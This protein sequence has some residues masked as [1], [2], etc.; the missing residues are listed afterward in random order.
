[1]APKSTTSNTD[2]SPEV[3]HVDFRTI[4]LQ[5]LLGPDAGAL[6][7]HGGSVPEALTLGDTLSD[8]TPL[9]EAR[10]YVSENLE[11]GVACPCC[12][13]H[14]QLHRWSL[15]PSQALGLLLL[16]WFNQKRPE[17]RGRWVHVT[18]FFAALGLDARTTM[19]LPPGFPKLRHWGLVEAGPRG[20]YRLTQLGEDFVAGKVRLPEAMLSYNDTFLGFT[21]QPIDIYEALGTTFNLRAFEFAAYRTE[22]EEAQTLEALSVLEVKVQQHLH[23][24]ALRTMLEARL[25]LICAMPVAA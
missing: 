15:L 20:H 4:P 11:A 6:S 19:I 2:W 12:G 9:S 3:G 22:I 10:A 23:A 21:G 17:H 24:A 18:R 8:D 25:D 16:F 7:F 5:D 14:T 1:M 13:Q